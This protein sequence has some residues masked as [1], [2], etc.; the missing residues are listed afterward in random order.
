ML[1]LTLILINCVLTKLYHVL[2]PPTENDIDIGHLSKWYGCFMPPLPPKWPQFSIS[3]SSKR[4]LS[5]MMKQMII[6]KKQNKNQEVKNPMR[7]QLIM[8]LIQSSGESKKLSM[9]IK[10][11]KNI[12]KKTEQFKSLAKEKLPSMSEINIGRAAVNF[13]DFSLIYLLDKCLANVVFTGIR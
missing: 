1:F 9:V 7:K 4:K 8:E 10:I 6:E 13:I 11:Q 12:L 3:S 5:I 2:R